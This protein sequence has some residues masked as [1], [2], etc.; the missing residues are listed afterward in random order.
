MPNPEDMHGAADGFGGSDFEEPEAERLAA[1]AAEPEPEPAPEPP[2]PPP[3]PVVTH[4]AKGPVPVVK[5]AP[6]PGMVDARVLKRPNRMVRMV[7]PRK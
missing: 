4:T 1:A 3:V 5:R 6:K 2:A 7:K